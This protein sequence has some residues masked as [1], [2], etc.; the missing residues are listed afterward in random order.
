MEGQCG[1]GNGVLRAQTEEP[2]RQASWLVVSWLAAI[3]INGISPLKYGIIWVI[4][5]LYMGY[6]WVIYGLYMGYIWVIYGLYMGYKPLPSSGMHIQVGS[7]AIKPT[8]ILGQPR[9]FAWFMSH[10]SGILMNE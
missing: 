5:G 2:R 3:E 6:I 7:M 9:Y 4:Y 8:E 10:S 1:G